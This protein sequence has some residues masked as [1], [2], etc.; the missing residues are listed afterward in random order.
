[1]RFGQGRAA[2]VIHAADERFEEVWLR[3]HVKTRSGWT[4]G[5]HG[6]LLE[7]QALTPDAGMWSARALLIGNETYDVLQA[8]GR[9]CIAGAEPLAG[10]DG[11]RDYE[12]DRLL[13]QQLGDEPIYALE[14]VERWRCLELHVR[15]N[16]L[17]KH[18]G[19]L[20]T[21]IDGLPDVTMTGLDYRGSWNGAPFNR[22]RMASWWPTAATVD[23]E[24][25]I[26]DIVLSRQRVP[27]N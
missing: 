25:L 1:M 20:E 27:C 9:S 14:S 21:W 23:Q 2:A 24:R 22:L 18:D 11:V 15:L 6:E 10:C 12:S 4:G 3:I 26:D 13:T 8:Q 16:E 19:V 5:G 7:L 17:G